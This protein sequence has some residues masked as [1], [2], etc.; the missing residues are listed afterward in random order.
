MPVP[1]WATPDGTAAYAR[2]FQDRAADGH[3]RSCQG[4]LLSSIGLGTYLGEPD[5][6]TDAAYTAAVERAFALGCNVFDTAINYRFQRSERSIGAAVRTL[7]RE[8]LLICTKAGF[9]TPD[10]EMPAD[11]RAYFQ[12]EYLDRGVLPREEIC[13]GM[14]CIAPQYLADQIERSLRNMD[15]ETI[16]VF[17]VHNPETQPPEVGQEEFHRRLRRAFE[18]LEAKVAEGKIRYYGTAT[19]NGYHR[20]PSARDHLGLEAIAGL[21]REVGGDGHH[22]RFV[23]LPHNLQMPEAFAA[24]LQPFKGKTTT[25]LKAAADLGITVVASASLMQAGLAHGLPP[26]IGESLSGLENDAERAIQFTRSTP[27]IAVALVGMSQVAHVEANLRLA[28]VPPASERQFM[29]LFTRS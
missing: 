6:E 12:R 28:Q 26:V 22:F 8:E 27:G 3:F 5:A 7:P 23:Q 25:L 15:L 21:A 10:G 1:G 20:P 9:L 19:W 18:M 16:D 24:P 4:L 13:G 14:H 2:R 11:P 29:Q 17:Y